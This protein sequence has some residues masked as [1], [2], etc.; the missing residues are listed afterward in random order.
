MALETASREFEPITMQS[1]EAVLRMSAWTPRMICDWEKGIA[2]E[3]HVLFGVRSSEGGLV[4][5][6]GISN[7]WRIPEFDI[8]I[9]ASERQRGLGS[10]ALKDLQ[11]IYLQMCGGAR[12]ALQVNAHIPESDAAQERLFA[13]L[14]FRRIEVPV[15]YERMFELD[16]PVAKWR[17][18]WRPK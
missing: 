17:W 12:M 18:E 9:I 6:A 13:K 8:F 5:V 7:I 11:N 2:R 1:K 15:A 14:G 4:G 3:S 16:E 10:R